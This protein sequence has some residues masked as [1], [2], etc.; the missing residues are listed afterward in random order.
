ML[1]FRILGPL[2]VVDGARPVALG[3]LK[4]RAT[5]AI[6]LL[7]ANRVVSVERLAE[8]LYSG[9]PP[10]TA[11]TQVQRQISELRK[12]LG[13]AAGI[14]T[15]APGYVIHVAAEQL[16]LNRFERLAEQAADALARGEAQRASDLLREA[17]A[18]WRG[19]PLADLAYEGFAQSTIARLDEIRMAALELRVEADLMIGRHGSLVAELESLV[20]D[21]P[22]RER[23][24]AQ[25][26]LAFYRSGRQPEALEAYRKLRAALVDEF[27]I[28]PGSAIQELE[29]A[30]LAH[31]PSLDLQPPADI[32][33]RTAVEPERSVLVL[34]SAFD[35]LAS[36][37]SVAE[38]LARRP[39][40]ELLVARLLAD[41]VGLQDANA[42]LAACRATLDVPMRTAVFTTAD[43][44]RDAV[45]L[46]T[47]HDVELMLLDAPSD[48]E[49]PTLPRSLA[50][51]LTHSPADVGVLAGA[52]VDW[53]QGAGIY[54]PFG[55][56]EHDWAAL[57]V[58]AQLAAVTEIHLRLVGTKAEPSRGRRDASRLLAD[59]SLSVQRVV[60]VDVEPLLAEATED[61]LLAAVSEATIVVAGIS[62]R[63]RDDGIGAA[64]RGLVSRSKRPVLLVHRGARPG[65][66]AP[67]GSQTRFSWS[68]EP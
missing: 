57:E 39:G 48:I 64:R 22:L 55:G 1:E 68:V 19:A 58:A 11:V 9:A 43:P 61:A 12:A 31:D 14:E 49:Q 7:N 66:L 25:Q 10:V 17:L 3:G 35:R 56:A 5:L 63:W 47:A 18:F 2:E 62:P 38:R 65:V 36:L 40:R 33:V 42:E 67:R 26:M 8:D 44:S 53:R 32:P 37:L 16:D 30:I 52:A 21:H 23:L 27:G 54:V 50:A 59:A 51:V 15:R 24:R 6:L 46:A 20:W 13:P 45:R 29:R 60:G 41:D 4:Q 28:E 34:P